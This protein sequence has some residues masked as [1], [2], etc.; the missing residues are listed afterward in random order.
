MAYQVLTKDL[1]EDKPNKSKSKSSDS[2]SPSKKKKNGIKPFYIHL[3]IIILLL[4]ALFFY[5]SE[6]FKFDF[7]KNEDITISGKTDNF[8]KNYS[9]NIILYSSNFNLQTSE[10]NFTAK[11]AESKLENFSG[12]I[13]LKNGSI[14]FEGT[15]SKIEYDKNTIQLNQKSFKLISSKE[16]ELNMYFQNITLNLNDGTISIVKD[17]DYDFKNATITLNEFNSTITYDDT[18]TFQGETKNLVFNSEKP[19]IQITYKNE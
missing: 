6:D 10:G 14:I 15:A 13:Y 11:S 3:T 9:G 19:Q 2:S 5:F 1:Y 18:F 8:A 4:L 7:S 16:T 12:Q 17:L